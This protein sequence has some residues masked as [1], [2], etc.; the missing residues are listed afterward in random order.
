[1][2]ERER[3]GE[4]GGGRGGRERGRERGGGRWLMLNHDIVQ[5]H[6]GLSLDTHKDFLILWIIVLHS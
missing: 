5:L 1:M 2:K 4:R 6:E 3:E